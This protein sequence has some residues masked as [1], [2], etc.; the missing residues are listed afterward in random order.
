MV[1]ADSVDS[2]VDSG[3]EKSYG[4]FQPELHMDTVDSELYSDRDDDKVDDVD[5]ESMFDE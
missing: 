4:G 1:H 5:V 2:S 3:M